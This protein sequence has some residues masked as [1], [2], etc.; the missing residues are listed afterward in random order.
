MTTTVMFVNQKG[1]VDKTTLADELLF[2][3]ERHSLECGLSASEVL[4]RLIDAAMP[5]WEGR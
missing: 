2:A 5:S 4:R 3:L 1:G